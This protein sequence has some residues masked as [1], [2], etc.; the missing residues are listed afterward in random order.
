MSNAIRQ[1]E[2]YRVQCCKADVKRLRELAKRRNGVG[3]SL[4]GWFGAYLRD[5]IAK[6][7]RM[8]GPVAPEPA[9]ESAPFHGLPDD[10][11]SV[12]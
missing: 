1:T 10:A 6:L 5:A 8:D 3:L 9:G 4:S 7:E 2:S 12:D 11:P